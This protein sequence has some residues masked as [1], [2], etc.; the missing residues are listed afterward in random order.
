MTSFLKSIRSSIATSDVAASSDEESRPECHALSRECIS[1]ELC[2]H[3]N[4]TR[5]ACVTCSG[6]I[7][8][9]FL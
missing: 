4:M 6:K 2:I 5:A 1:I 3:L 7:L 9:S 8:L